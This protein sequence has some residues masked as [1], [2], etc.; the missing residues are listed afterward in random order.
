M[1][2]ERVASRR[3]GSALRFTSRFNASNALDV[4]LDMAADLRL[5]VQECD[6]FVGTAAS[7]VSRVMLLAIGGGN[8]VE[9]G[10]LPGLPPHVFLDRPFGAVTWETDRSAWHCKSPRVVH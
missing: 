6:A 1:P 3:Y 4:T 9:R 8:A 10:R 5:L 7:W 2:F